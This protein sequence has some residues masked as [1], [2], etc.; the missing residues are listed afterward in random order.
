MNKRPYQKTP[1][2]FSAHSN[3]NYASFASTICW[4]ENETHFSVFVQIPSL[5]STITSIF[6]CSVL[7]NYVTQ[8]CGKHDYVHSHLNFKSCFEEKCDPFQDRNSAKEIYSKPIKHHAMTT[9]VKVYIQ[10]NY[11]LILDASATRVISF[12]PWPIYPPGKQ[13]F[14][15][16]PTNSL[17][18]MLSYLGS[19]INL[20]NAFTVC[21]SPSLW[22]TNLLTLSRLTV[23][24]NC[25]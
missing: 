15:G 12:K 9:C 19:H 24:L 11:S 23:I 16:G 22:T 2:A 8:V 21:S 17:V 20:H 7:V 6:M 25:K 1:H 18:I 13:G 10:P 14:S 4:C 5:F 3:T